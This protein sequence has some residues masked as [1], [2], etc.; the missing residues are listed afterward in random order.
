M[1]LTL[2]HAPWGPCSP[3]YASPEQAKNDKKNILFKSDFFSLGVLA[4]EL[5]TEENPFFN[6]PELSNDEILDNVC[7]IIPPSLFSLGKSGSYS[8]MWC[9]GT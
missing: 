9:M 6:C 3:P 8:Q 2:T 1:G 4:Y 7:K 5:M